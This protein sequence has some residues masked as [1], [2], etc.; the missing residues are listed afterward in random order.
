MDRIELQNFVFSSKTNRRQ[1]L[2]YTSET[3]KKYKI[4]VFRNHSFELVE[5]TISAYLDY[6][7]IGVS[8]EYSGYDD[9]FSFSEVDINADAIIVWVDAKRYNTDNVEA[10]LKSRLEH[11]RAIYSKAILLVPY[12]CDYKSEDNSI[13]VFP[14]DDIKNELGSKFTDERVASVTGTSL[15]NA[16][17]LKI[18]K[19]L[20][21]R[22]IPAI[23][24]PSLKAVVVDFDNTLY[25]GVLGEDGIEGIEITEGHKK[26]QKYL[27]ELSKKGIFLCAASK[28]EAEDVEN[29]LE[30][31]TDFEVKREDFTKMCVSWQP[32][33]ESIKEISEYLNIG[34]D[35]ILMVDDNIG[36]VNALAFAYPELKL[37][38]AKD[39]ANETC[40]VLENYPGL[41]LLNT[42]AESAIRKDDVIANE[43]RR[44]MKSSVENKEDYIKS[45]QIRLTY[46]FDNKE[47]LKR[48]SELANKTNQ[49]IFN[50]KRYTLQEIENIYQSDD[51]MIV[52]I[53]LEDCLSNSGLIA[54]CVGKKIDDCMILEE[55]FM[56]CRALGRGIDD[57]IIM[58][59][60][61]LITER[62]HVK[63]VEVLFKEGERNTPAKNYIES[64]LSKYVGSAK[65]FTY[66]FPEGLVDIDIIERSY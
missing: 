5:H 24:K 7:G 21:L 32:K 9:S 49:F 1:L 27:K 30:K 58:G 39:D 26:L 44:L 52:S 43:K 36:E 18:S 2:E 16:A 46:D 19:E 56:S 15:S 33:A 59:A 45:L 13:V 4:Q 8:F 55:C 37:L 17:M 20:G 22:Y 61:K 31:R 29:L 14:L 41:L 47:K 42:T 23:L 62:L 10:F 12:G 51:Y 34:I 50:Y 40:E 48:I 6:A 25:K 38:H 63:K 28:N 60:I 65:E 35:S 64:Y 66:D 11:L 53:S 57:V 3:E 54:V